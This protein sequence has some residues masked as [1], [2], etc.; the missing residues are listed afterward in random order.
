M[1]L[2][3]DIYKWPSS[4]FYEVWFLSQ[5]LYIVQSIA[6]ITA[7]VPCTKYGSYHSCCT[8]FSLPPFSPVPFFLVLF[9]SLYI[10]H[11]CKQRCSCTV[12]HMQMHT[13]YALSA[14]HTQSCIVRSGKIWE[15]LLRWKFKVTHV[16]T[17]IFICLKF[18][19]LHDSSFFLKYCIICN[20]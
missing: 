1:K 7:V 12:L 11:M 17:N 14:T 3:H 19:I 6:S 10:C 9:L 18:Y 5:L 8:L 16:S 15:D 2:L 20:L 4:T 13:A